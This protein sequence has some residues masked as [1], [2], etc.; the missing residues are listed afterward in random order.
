M[1]GVIFGILNS[2]A[3]GGENSLLKALLLEIGPGSAVEL[4]IPA[5]FKASRP[6]RMNN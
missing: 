3:F 5:R 4:F 6:C 2:S 1:D